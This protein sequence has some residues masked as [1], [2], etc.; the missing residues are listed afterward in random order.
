VRA[1]I[2]VA[3]GIALVLSAGVE[4]RSREDKPFA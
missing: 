1:A 3:V 4:R 2:P